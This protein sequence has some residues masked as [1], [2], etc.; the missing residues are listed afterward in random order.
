MSMPFDDDF[1]LLRNPKQLREVRNQ[2][3]NQDKGMTQLL[4][5]ISGHNDK[6]KS[7]NK[8]R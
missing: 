4:D 8:Y 7:K 2:I 1:N 3:K 6:K 5:A